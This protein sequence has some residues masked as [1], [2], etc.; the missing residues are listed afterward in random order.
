MKLSDFAYHLPQELF[1]QYPLEQRSGSRLLFLDKETKKIQHQQFHDFIHH[2]KP[3]DL[4]VFNDTKVIPA[5]LFGRKPSGGKVEIFVERLMPNNQVLALMRASKPPKVDSLIHLTPD[6]AVRVLSKK[7]GMVVLQFPA[8]VLP[9]L[10]TLGKVPI[11]PYMLRDADSND[12]ARYQTIYARHQGAVAAPTA[13]LHFDE[14]TFGALAKKGVGIDYVTLH[15]GAGTFQPV[16]VEDI[17]RHVMHAEWLEVSPQL[18]QRIQATK[19]AGGRVVA[20]GTTTVRSLETAALGGEIQPFSGDT[21]IFIYPG[22]TF[23][24]VDALLTN[25]HLPES[26]LIMLVAALGGYEA[27][28]QAYKEAVTENYR[29][30]SYGDA[31]FLG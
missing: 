28:M 29:F 1:A 4:L 8:P 14:A 31:M 17:Q 30:F 16:R 13:G 3:N 21:R 9:I 23:R 10:E 12:E 20:V 18:C 26:T 2:L 7:E 27:V 11:P 15:V 25:F 5:R 22:F 6:L 24:C 19:A